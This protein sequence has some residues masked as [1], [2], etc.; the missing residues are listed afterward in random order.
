M[1]RTINLK[2]KI[3]ELSKPW[4]PIEISQVNDQVVR[5]ALYDGEYPWHKHTDG[6]ELFYVYRGSIVIRVRGHPNITLYEGEIAVMPK[7]VEHSPK[8]I[9][10]SFVLMFEPQALK[11]HGDY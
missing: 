11:S 7:G 6:D 4:S 1:I 3:K 9:E 8:S 5:L 2:D 10:P